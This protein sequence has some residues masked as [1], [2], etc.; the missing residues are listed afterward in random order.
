MPSRDR[1][2]RF[3]RAAALAVLTATA[4]AGHAG[5]TTGP[6]ARIVSGQLFLGT[7]KVEVGSRVNGSFGSSIAAPAGYTP[8]TNSGT[9]LGFRVNPDE[10]DWTAGSCVTL[11]DYFTPG[12]PYE[13]WGIQVGATA[14]AYNTNSVTGVPGAFQSADT[15]TISGVWRATAPHQGVDVTWRYSVPSYA[16]LIDA[17]A[18]LTNTTGATIN[19]IHVLRGLDPDLCRMEARPLCDSDGDG[20]A[21]GSGTSLGVYE[22]LNTVVS[23]G[24]SGGNAVVTATQTNGSYLGLRVIGGGRAFRQNSGFTNPANLAVLYAGGN[25]AYTDTAGSAQYGDDGIYVVAKVD[26]LAPG[27]SRTLRFQYVVRD[28]PAAADLAREVPA[29]G[30]LVDV[31][32]ANPAGATLRGL[33]TAPAHGTA[34]IEAGGI[35]YTPAAGY[36]GP[37]TFSYSTGGPC[38][39]VSVTVL[40]AAAAAPAPERAEDTRV[41]VPVRPLVRRVVDGHARV[42]SDLTLLRPGRYT[43]IYLDPSG[44]RIGQLKGSRVGPRTLRTRHSA[45]VLVT[46]TAGRTVRLVSDLARRAPT[47][48]RLR[49]VH[50]AP[51]GTLADVVVS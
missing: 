12:A 22:T 7:T 13:A 10:C 4:V 5:A 19:D 20:T 49:I 51:D 30:A 1:A 38:G 31:L 43:F 36:S 23:H 25:G 47:G 18:T 34:T 15:G 42:S 33:C 16:W 17:E 39:T 9:I 32:A 46:T 21:D 44:R 40:P 6:D 28:V 41:A 29:G 8:N 35:R 45:P 26:A 3:R 37:D 2:R 27:E 11:G 48:T 24:A 50:R 14:P